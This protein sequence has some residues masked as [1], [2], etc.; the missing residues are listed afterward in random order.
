MNASASASARNAS[1]DW[2]AFARA[3]DEAIETGYAR[4]E[5]ALV[6]AGCN[7]FSELEPADCGPI[8]EM[9]AEQ[10]LHLLHMHKHQVHGAGGKPGLQM[11]HDKQ[12]AQATERLRKIMA[13][14]FRD[15]PEWV[16]AMEE[17]QAAGFGREKRR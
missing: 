4:I 17:K 5:A 8:R 10:A 12:L 15:D 13:V 2:P 3:W 6:E 7:I 16:R 11:P 1:S 14:V 9:T